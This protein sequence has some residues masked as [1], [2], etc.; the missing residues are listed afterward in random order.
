M[1]FHIVLRN[2]QK[3]KTKKRTQLNGVPTKHIEK[4]K[5]VKY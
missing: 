2:T 4:C 1:L 5:K 3:L